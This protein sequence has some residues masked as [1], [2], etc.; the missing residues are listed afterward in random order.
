MP[1]TRPPAIFGI[2][3]NYAEH[4]AEMGGDAP[5]RP[6]VFMKNPASVIG[7]GEAIRIPAICREPRPQVD[8]EG[9]LAVILDR[10]A[11]NVPE[12]DALSV[13]RGYAPANDV[14]A[15]WWQKEGAGGQF[16]RGKSFDTF[17]PLGPIIAAA[18]VP[19][20]QAL[21]LVTT[22][23]GDVMQEA[24][25]SAMIFP[26]A[27]LIAELSRGLTLLAGTVILT[28]TPAGVGAARTPPRF[29]QD[30][31]E[32]EVTIEVVGAVRNLVREE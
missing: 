2:G 22:L 18:A 6:L 25:T 13:V 28:G 7:H 27:R 24:H 9:E 32:V 23:N 29:L 8:Y 11:R 4:A 21:R 10:D 5:A 17:C 20:P 3:R 1:V 31:D 12:R 19:D 26:V 30:G 16:V 14:S 15:R